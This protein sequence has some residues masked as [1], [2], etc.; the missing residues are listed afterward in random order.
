MQVSLSLSLTQSLTHLQTKYISLS[1]FQD[2]YH[3]GPSLFLLIPFSHSLLT[4]TYSQCRVSW[5]PPCGWASTR[6]R[7][8]SVGATSPWSSWP[9][10][11]SPRLRYCCFFSLQF[12]TRIISQKVF[13]SAV[14]HC[15]GYHFKSQRKSFLKK[16]LLLCYF[17]YFSGI[18]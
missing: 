12:V 14:Q 2:F 5:V 16:V 6:S 15:Y 8:R 3:Y 1:A 7:T 10:T 4:H 13:L 18:I 11:G 17:Q 9:S